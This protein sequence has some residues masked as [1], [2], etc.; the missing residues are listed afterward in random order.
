M[1]FINL[2]DGLSNRNVALELAGDTLKY[3]DYENPGTGAETDLEKATCD[4]I[5]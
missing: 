3:F 5:I 4:G 2:S 1:V